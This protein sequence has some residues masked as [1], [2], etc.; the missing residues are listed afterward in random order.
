MVTVVNNRVS[1]QFLDDFVN[2]LPAGLNVEPS[3]NSLVNVCQR[4]RYFLT[5]MES[6]SKIF[7][8]FPSLCSILAFDMDPPGLAGGWQDMECHK[9]MLKMHCSAK[10]KQHKDC[11]E[12]AKTELILVIK[13]LSPGE[14]QKF[15]TPGVWG[16]AGALPAAGKAGGSNVPN[17]S[18]S[19]WE[20][21][22]TLRE[23]KQQGTATRGSINHFHVP[24]ISWEG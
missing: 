8:D 13:A 16:G 14:N 21:K 2:W 11:T 1:K 4:K 20:I 24:I 19:C 5:D 17:T 22:L 15:L 6:F 18:P 3:S 12:Q 9:K 7:I 23:H 10:E